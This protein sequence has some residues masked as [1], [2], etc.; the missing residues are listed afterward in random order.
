MT[1]LTNIGNFAGM[2]FARFKLKEGVSE[3]TML[4][5]IKE[6]DAN[7]LQKEE[8]FL[9]HVALKGSNG[10]YADVVFATSQE[11]AQKIC[12][13][14][15]DNAFALKYIELIDEESVDMTFWNRIK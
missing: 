6:V 8:G 11:K 2:E 7:F 9:G 3:E 4:E 1:N 14:W 15:M 5:I 10:I 12:G 13:K